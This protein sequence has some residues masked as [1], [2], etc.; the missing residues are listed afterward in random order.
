MQATKKSTGFTLIELSIVLV[1][2]A[3]VVGSVLV[4]RDLIENAKIRKQIS[5][6]EQLSQATHTFTVKYNVLP[7]DVCD[8]ATELG[9]ACGNATGPRDNGI[10]D[11][12]NG[13][14]PIG[15]VAY[16]PSYFFG[17]LVLAK[18]IP[19]TFLTGTSSFNG[20]NCWAGFSGTLPY[21]YYAL[22]IEPK[23]GMVAQSWEGSTWFYL[24]ISNCNSVPL[25]A[26]G[27]GGADTNGVL[28]PLR[29]FAIDT[30]LDNGVPGTGQ[31]LAFRSDGSGYL[32]R[33]DTTANSCVVSVAAL[34]YNITDNTTKCRL[35]VKS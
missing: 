8:M 21:G 29:A 19:S 5:Q 15:G 1:I 24:G 31:V 22:S 9:L 12:I 2:I 10:I 16:E 32:N 6:L 4:G 7:G 20:G 18:L 26:P 30:K 28:T 34:A 3:L 14:S 13:D 23:S 11:D 27:N 35:L 33:L 17:H 25:S